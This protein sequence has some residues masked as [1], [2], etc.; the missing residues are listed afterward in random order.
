MHHISIISSS[1]RPDRNS[2]RVALYFK[3]Y[4]T[5][6]N[7]ATTEIIDLKAYNFPIFDTPLK[8]Q[9]SPAANT[10]EFAQK[11][12]ASDGIILVTPEYNGGYPASLKNAIDLLYEEWRHKPIAISTVSSGDFGGSQCLTALQFTLFKMMAWT[13][14]AVFPVPKVV[15]HYDESG[16][17]TDKAKTD[18]LA[19]AFVKELL[20]CVRA[21]KYKFD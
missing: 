20:W 9:K 21:D 5:E 6:N 19:A 3:N 17:P 11:I 16:K 7:L 15:E 4:L 1:I 2:H 10:V 14:P 18:K 12:K 8:Y 13:I